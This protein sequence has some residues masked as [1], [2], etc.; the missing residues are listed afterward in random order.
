T[1]SFFRCESLKEFTIPNGIV[2]IKE[3]AFE[4]TKA[5]KTIIIPASVVTI[6][7]NAFLESGLESAIYLGDINNLKIDSEGNNILI[8]LLS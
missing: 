4:Q 8:D 2:T 3:S 7:K 5:L 1:R 6:E